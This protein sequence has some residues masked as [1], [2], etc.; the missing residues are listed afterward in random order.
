MSP[1]ERRSTSPPTSRRPWKTS[2]RRW[3]SLARRPPVQ[4]KH[5]RNNPRPLHHQP[6]AR[7][8]RY[9]PPPQHLPLPPYKA[10]LRHPRRL[11]RFP[12]S[13]LPRR[14]IETMGKRPRRRRSQRSSLWRIPRRRRRPLN[15]RPP[16]SRSMPASKGCWIKYRRKVS[17]E[18]WRRRDVQQLVSQNK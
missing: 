5:R 13:R 3:V 9:M 11:Q 14:K 12:P 6:V 17:S 1:V 18:V 15:G 8:R 10:P 4:S 16:A 2:A 7:G